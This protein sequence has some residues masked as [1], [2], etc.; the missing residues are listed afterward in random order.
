[1]AYQAYMKSLEGKERKT[2]DGFTPEQRFFL[3]YAVS[4]CENIT[5]DLAR[6]MVDT[7]PHSPG[8]FRLI[9]AVSNMPEFWKAFSCKPGQPMVRGNKACK[10]W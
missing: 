2:V 7:D 5:D 4:R 8:K 6:I 10:V 1:M 3:G 9:G